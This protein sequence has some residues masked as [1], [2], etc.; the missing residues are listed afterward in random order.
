MLVDRSTDN[1]ATTGEHPVMTV[2][3]LVAVVTILIAT[4]EI[5]VVT[6]EIQVMTGEVLIRAGEIRYKMC[7]F[8]VKTPSDLV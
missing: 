8:Q 2:K 1:Q 7:L 5:P 4:G 6:G 3:I